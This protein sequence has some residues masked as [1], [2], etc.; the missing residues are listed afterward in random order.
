MQDQLT[1]AG[2]VAI[3]LATFNGD[4]FLSA[5]LDSLES[6]LHQDWFVIA[7]DDGSTDNTLKILQKYQER[8]P[9]GKLSIRTGP[10]QGFCHNFLSMACDSAIKA[11][12]YA[13][14]DQDGVC[15]R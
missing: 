7:S 14:C 9:E 11:D 4:R 6:Q 3:L 10:E 15:P 1:P 5:Q 12:F 2:R 13:F 8:W